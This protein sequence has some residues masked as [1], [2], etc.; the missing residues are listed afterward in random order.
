MSLM[1]VKVRRTSMVNSI[2]IPEAAKSNTP[3][4]C[5]MR[6]S[7]PCS[8]PSENNPRKTFTL[9]RSPICWKIDVEG[10]TTRSYVVSSPSSDVAPVLC[11]CSKASRLDASSQAWMM[12]KS[13]NP[14][15]W[16]SSLS[17]LGVLMTPIALS[18]HTCAAHAAAHCRCMA[19]LDSRLEDQVDTLQPVG[20]QSDQPSMACVY[21]FG[22]TMTAASGPISIAVAAPTVKR[23][24]G[25]LYVSTATAS[26][27][28]PSQFALSTQAIVL[29]NAADPLRVPPATSTPSIL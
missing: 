24:S 14:S 16:L 10:R 7:I 8:S 11:S 20:W 17:S 28:R 1:L 4:R 12:S 23:S 19:F 15:A 18:A 5:C 25:V 21:R 27:C 2:A 9:R 22:F 13:D 29:S 6:V 26:P 3:M